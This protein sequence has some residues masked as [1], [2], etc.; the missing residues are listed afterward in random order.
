MTQKERD[1]KKP[2][3]DLLLEFRN[4][5]FCAGT[6]YRAD[7]LLKRIKE[8]VGGSELNTRDLEIAYG[9]IKLGEQT[10]R[11]E[12]VEALNVILKNFVKYD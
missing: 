4:K 2:L 10:A 11:A 5:S 12:L 6:H 3:A 1:N 9:H 8:K 7:Q